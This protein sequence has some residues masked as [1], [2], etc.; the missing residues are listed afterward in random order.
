[1]RAVGVFGHN[2][3]LSGTIRVRGYTGA[4]HTS[5]VFDTT[6][7]NPFTIYPSG[8][9]EAGHPAFGTTELAQE[10]YDAGYPVP[11]MFVLATPVSA[12]YLWF[13]FDD[14]S[15]PDTFVELGRPWAS[16]G[17]QPSHGVSVGQRIRWATQTKVEETPGGANLYDERPRRRIIDIGLD[18]FEEDE[19]LVYLTE[20]NRRLGTH[21]QCMYIA[22]P[23]ATVHMHRTGGLF[24][25]QSLRP[26]AFRRSLFNDQGFTLLEEL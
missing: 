14:T 15:N 20:L 13:T 7:V 3:S 4:A 9:L 24:T 25:L 21:G 1:M 8:V 12:R 5:E 16:Y 26:M 2:L 19:S 23:D 22:D 17:Y 11:W 18:M 6:A 10:D